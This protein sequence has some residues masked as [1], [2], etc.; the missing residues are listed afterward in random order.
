MGA[1]TDATTVRL[2]LQEAL[3][4][5]DET[6]NT[7]QALTQERDAL[8]AE[9]GPLRDWGSKL[10]VEHAQQQ[11]EIERLRAMMHSA[12]SRLRG[13]DEMQK[14]IDTL[15]AERDALKSRP[16]GNV[17]AEV[18]MSRARQLA[19]LVRALEPFMWGLTQA[20]EFY[21]GASVVGGDAHVKL[22]Q[23]L[24]GVLLRLRNEIAMLDLG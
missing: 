22:L 9:A 3:M 17:D 2:D 19:D 4:R 8:R 15:S 14:Q 10:V 20:K 24:E 7:L 6:S 5:L 11:G 18:F 1:R 21:R 16:G 23:Q 12:D 13:L